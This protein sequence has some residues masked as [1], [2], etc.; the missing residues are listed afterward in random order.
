MNHIGVSPSVACIQGLIHQLSHFVFFC[1]LS[2]SD[3]DHIRGW[4]FSFSLSQVSFSLIIVL[5]QSFNEIGFD[6]LIVRNQNSI[7]QLGCSEL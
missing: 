5:T 6:L 3:L 4:S 7:M 2:H 1:N